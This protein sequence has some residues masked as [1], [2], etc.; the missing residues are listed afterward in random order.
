MY[1]QATGQFGFE[2][3]TIA[4]ATPISQSSQHSNNMHSAHTPREQK[5]QK[6]IMVNVNNLKRKVT[7]A[8]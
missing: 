5:T 2:L 7:A 6:Q 8:V 1:R 4:V 3:N